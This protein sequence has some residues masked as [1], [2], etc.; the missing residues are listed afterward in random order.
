VK[1][2]LTPTNLSTR[3]LVNL[4]TCQPINLLPRM[5]LLSSDDALLD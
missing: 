4:F 5:R 3:Q 2:W 1:R